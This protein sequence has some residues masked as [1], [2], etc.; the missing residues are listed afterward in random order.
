MDKY[1]HMDLTRNIIGCFFEIHNHLGPGFLEQTYKNAL[2]REFI[3]NNIRYETEKEVKIHYKNK[4]IHY[5]RLDLLVENKII[6]EVKTV[7]NFHPMH[8]AQ[9]IAYL[10]AAQKEVGLLVNFARES[11]QFKRFANLYNR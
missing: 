8:E 3:D 5:H 11:V 6:I 4:L 7:E 2:K 10:K 9:V 1:P